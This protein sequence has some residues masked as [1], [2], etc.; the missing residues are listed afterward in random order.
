MKSLS[1]R[2][3]TLM[4]EKRGRLVRNRCVSL[5]GD[6]ISNSKGLDVAPVLGQRFDQQTGALQIAPALDLAQSQGENGLANL[7]KHRLGCL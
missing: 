7:G 2:T 1:G 3:E 5:P 4:L 6:T